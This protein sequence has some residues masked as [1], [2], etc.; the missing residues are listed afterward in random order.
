M[1]NLY[2]ILFEQ[3]IAEVAF[4]K[5]FL[6]NLENVDTIILEKAIDFLKHL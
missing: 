6:E 1:Q 3:P 5:S 4:H 2:L